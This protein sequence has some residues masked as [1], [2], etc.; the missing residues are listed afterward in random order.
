MKSIEILDTTLR[1][2]AQAEGISFS[3]R[4]KL[5]IVAT[6]DALG[7]SLIEAGN[8]GSNPKDISFFKEL[9]GLL[10]QQGK[11]AAFGATCR[12]GKPPEDDPQV[13]SLLQ[14]DT[15]VVVIFGKSWNLHVTDV[16]RTTPEENLRMIADTVA[17][18]I[19]HG[20]RVIFDAEHFF[21]GWKADS[22]YALASL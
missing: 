6:L 1:D 19:R 12:P 13:L 15:D 4:D 2:G 8:P 7:I 3:V 16:L 9:S 10:L 22:D 18:F 11:V 14:A 20:K 17:F 5:Q 21:D